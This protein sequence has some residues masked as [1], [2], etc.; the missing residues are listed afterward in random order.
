[1]ANLLLLYY[2]YITFIHNFSEK[3]IN[4]ITTLKNDRPRNKNLTGSY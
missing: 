2:N 4:Y 3:S 1:M